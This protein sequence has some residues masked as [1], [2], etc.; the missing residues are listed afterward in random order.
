MLL[1]ENV[2]PNSALSVGDNDGV[3]LIDVT[4]VNVIRKGTKKKLKILLI[5]GNILNL[6]IQNIRIIR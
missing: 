3:H 2:E 5:I 4:D 1:L 6:K